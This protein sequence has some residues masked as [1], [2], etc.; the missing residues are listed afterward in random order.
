MSLLGKARTPLRERYPYG[1]KRLRVHWS[2]D[3]ATSRVRTSRV[4]LAFPSTYVWR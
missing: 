2:P 1:V 3:T 4:A